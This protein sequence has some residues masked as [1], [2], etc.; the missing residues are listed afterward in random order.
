MGS[1]LQ[2]IASAVFIWTRD[3]YYN[4]DKGCALMICFAMLDGWG[5]AQE[6]FRSFMSFPTCGNNKDYNLP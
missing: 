1:D 5:T 2:T 3:I 6:I 4:T